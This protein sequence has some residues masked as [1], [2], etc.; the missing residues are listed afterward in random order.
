MLERIEQQLEKIVCASNT[1][2]AHDIGH[3]KRVVKNAKLLAIAEQGV[4]E[5]VI[6]A[7]WLHDIVSLAK[8]HPKR[9]LASSLAADKAL[10]ILQGINYP[11]QYLEGIHQAIA[12]HSYSANIAAI[13]IEAKI[14]QDAD[15]LDALGAVGIA[16][17]FTV[18]GALQRPLYQSDDPF[19]DNRGLDDSG[20]CIDHFYQKLF[21][22]AD[23]M[24][25]HTAKQLAQQRCK[26]MQNFLLQLK[27]EI[28]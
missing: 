19:A 5:I 26:Y 16:R 7:A 6:P 11:K 15:R 2:V 14:V 24:H 1:D 20:Y 8:D 22:L 3:I 25:T 13:G 12:A 9:A 4:A 18:S 17:C 27:S 21:K 23:K 10:E 28:E